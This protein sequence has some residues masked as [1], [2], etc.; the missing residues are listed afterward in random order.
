MEATRKGDELDARSE[1]GRDIPRPL[2]IVAGYAWRLVVILVAAAAIIYA[3]AKLRLIVL[4][5][6]IALL[7]STL[8]APLV[9]RLKRRR[10]KPALA[11]WTV[12]GAAIL[13]LVGFVALVSPQVAAQIGDMG[14]AVREGS[15]QVLEWLTRGPLDLSQEEIQG[16]IDRM[17]QRIRENSSSITGGVVSG[18]IAIGEGIAGLFLTLVLLFFFLKDGDKICGWILRQ[19]SE[20]QRTHVAESGKRAWAALGGYVRGTAVVALVDAVLIGILLAVL[21]VPLLVPLVVLTFFGAFFPLV[22][23][24][25]AGIVAALVALVTEGVSDA[26]IVGA[27]ILVIQQVEGDVLQPLVLGRSVKLH[28]IVI[29]LSLTAGAILAGIAGAFL[30]VPVTA[31]A[32]SV[33]SYLRGLGRPEG[34]AGAYRTTE[35]GAQEA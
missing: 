30:A 31:V 1:R 26:L 5:V 34:D 11:T 29:L 10:W 7:L 12:F 33:G 18:A 22:G 3:L 15:D 19:F 2:N 13:L 23:A 21:G 9:D 32:V 24:T 25:V 17:G 35:R 16:F 28:P 14:D 4:P 8:L 27:G 20:P 6:I